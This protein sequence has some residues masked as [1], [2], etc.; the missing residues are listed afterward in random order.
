M[1]IRNTLLFVLAASIA[2]LPGCGSGD[3]SPGGQTAVSYRVSSPADQKI[4]RAKLAVTSDPTDAKSHIA[5]AAAYLQK[6]RET[7]DYSINR[8]AYD[9]IEKAREIEPESFEADVLETQIHL[10]VHEFEKALLIAS[11]LETSYPSS[12]AVLAAKTDALTELGRYPE[13]VDAAQKFVD[14]KPNASSY[15]RVAHLRSLYGD[16]EGAIEARIM[17]AQMAD[18]GDPETY[19]W[20][21]SQVGSEYLLAGDDARA[22]NAFDR[23]LAA[24]PDYHWALEGK[25]K[26]LAA[27]G[28]VGR[29]LETYIK[30]ISRA[31][32]TNRL[33]Y[34]GD[35]LW[36]LGS[37]PEAEMVYRCAVKY[38]GLADNDLHRIALHWADRGK[39]LNEA[40]RIA[41]EDRKVNDDLAASDTLAWVLHK[42]GMDVQAKK[43]MTL[44]MRLGTRN[45]LFYYHLG[46]IEMSLGNER[47]ASKQLRRA[48]ETNPA[49]DLVQAEHARQALRALEG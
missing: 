29:A 3:A 6:V 27:R 15:S 31:P 33:I 5:L 34:A 28:L 32:S 24:L 42:K 40:F 1:I 21:L 37:R 4:V 22:E 35:L 43:E 20:Y 8:L 10:S 11:K 7:G 38:A 44:A 47:E 13:A 14:T 41:S 18:P 49:F 45:A 19:A 23:A 36:K 17:A 39:N 30:L 9:S 25:G 26:A 48:L 12:E 46:M 2:C 16:R